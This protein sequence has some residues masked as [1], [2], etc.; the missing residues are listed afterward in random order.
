M[1]EA[2]GYTV[3]E[4]IEILKQYPNDLPVLV[5][6]YENGYENFYP[7]TVKKVKH[8]PKNKYWDGEFQENENGS[9]ALILERRVRNKFY[10]V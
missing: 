3:G 2:K 5:S 8:F 10:L 6:G 1:T 9:D 4:L 7:P